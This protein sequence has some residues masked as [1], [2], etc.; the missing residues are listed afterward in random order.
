LPL[1]SQ[2]ARTNHET[3]LKIST[4]DELFDEEPG[5]DGLPGSGVIGE[6]KAER[7]PRE[8]LFVNSRYLMRKGLND[9]RVHCEDGIE[10]VGKMDTMC[11]RDESKQSA[12]PV[13]APWPAHLSH[14]DRRL[15]ISKKQLVSEFP[16]RIF[17]G[18]FDTGSPKPFHVNNCDEPIG[19]NPFQRCASRDFL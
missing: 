18:E 4:S 11:F 1:L 14:F 12:I 3:A 19:K 15:T 8:H 10:K 17:I 2:A 16:L 6:Q 7:L 13:E 5:H 9:G